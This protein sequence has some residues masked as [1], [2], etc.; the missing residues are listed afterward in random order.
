MAGACH[1]C[2]LC[3]R[4]FNAN[5][6]FNEF[7]RKLQAAID[8]VK[9]GNEK[10]TVED[11]IRTKERMLTYLKK[12]Q[13]SSDDSDRLE[14]EITASE[15]QLRANED[16]LRRLRS[17][18]EELKTK[19]Q[20]AQQDEKE[21]KSVDQ[22]L[23]RLDDWM[24]EGRG[25]EKS[26]RV[27]EAK[28]LGGT[29]GKSMEEVTQQQKVVRDQLD[30]A[31][32][33]VAKWNGKQQQ[34]DKDKLLKSHRIN[35]CKT[36]RLE[37]KQEIEQR[38]RQIKRKDHLRE[39]VPN[40]KQNIAE[41]HGQVQDARQNLETLEPRETEMETDHT[42]AERALDDEIEQLKEQIHELKMFADQVRSYEDNGKEAQLTR[43]CEEVQ[44]KIEENQVLQTEI[45][46][47]STDIQT[48]EE[49]RGKRDQMIRNMDDNLDFREK[50]AEIDESSRKIN[51]YTTT[52]EGI[53]NRDNYEELLAKAGSEWRRRLNQH[54]QIKGSKNQCEDDLARLNDDLK[55]Y[56]TA[57]REHRESLIKVKTM[58]MACAGESCAPASLCQLSEAHCFC[59]SDRYVL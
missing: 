59:V 51:E 27:E 47:I 33:E 18:Q 48:R 24:E 54:G 29:K 25:Y 50:M 37:I 49:N 38:E 19:T 58:E 40:A 14:G 26:L 46:K 56:T 10:R 41:L 57:D 21:A 52:L 32:G 4:S 35:E 20:Q 55:S 45:E 5:S 53:A 22:E 44:R 7:K 12:N 11:G 17:R 8:D 30:D 9:S 31:G 42:A 1:G 2:P 6:E 15:Q 36:E 28:L 16:T 3:E 39:H 23:K 34:S 43:L 13:Q